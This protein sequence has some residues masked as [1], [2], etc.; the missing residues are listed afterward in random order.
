[1]RNPFVLHL[2]R[3]SWDTVS[4][5][6]LDQ[7]NRWQIYEGFI[8][9]ILNTQQQV[10]S[11]NVQDSLQSDYPSLLASYQAFA[12]DVAWKSFE[13]GGITLGYNQADKTFGWVDIKSLVAQEARE[14]FKKRQAQL[15]QADKAKQG[16]LAR[17]SLLQEDDYVRMKINQ[18]QQFEAELPLKARGEGEEQ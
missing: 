13:Q 17:R 12:S 7:L 2:L 4:K 14:D 11:K 5:K 1:L 10:L 3:Q 6:D 16:Q 8:E 15:E 18:V 9:H